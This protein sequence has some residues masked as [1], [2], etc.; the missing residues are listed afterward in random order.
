MENVFPIFIAE[1]KISIFFARPI[2]S[3]KY[4]AFFVEGLSIYD[5][6]ILSV[7]GGH[8]L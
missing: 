8:R 7:G 3:I 1:Q 6:T 4:F 5:V 2:L